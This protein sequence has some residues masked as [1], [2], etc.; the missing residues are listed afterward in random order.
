LF[1]DI[2]VSLGS[3]TRS[4][5]KPDTQCWIR[6]VAD[7]FQASSFRSG[8]SKDGPGPHVPTWS[9]N[10]CANFL[11]S[12]PHGEDEREATLKSLGPAQTGVGQVV[13]SRSV[14]A[15]ERWV[16]DWPEAVCN[17]TVR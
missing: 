2:R 3:D 12:D 5:V 17:K 11:G 16:V 7:A 10:H 8:W 9:T 13:G 15:T 14:A 6:T 1:F 4:G